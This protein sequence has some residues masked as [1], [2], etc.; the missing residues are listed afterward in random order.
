MF[1][2]LLRSE[3][4]LRTKNVKGKVRLYRDDDKAL[5]DNPNFYFEMSKREAAKT[6]FALIARIFSI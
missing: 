6:I 4:M 3:K 2:L 5:Q 1:L